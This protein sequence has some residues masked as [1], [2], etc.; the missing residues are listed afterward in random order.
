MRKLLN[1]CSVASF[2]GYLVLSQIFGMRI[3]LVTYF[4]SGHYLNEK[5]AT[6]IS[7]HFK[8]MSL[9]ASEPLKNQQE[10]TFISEGVLRSHRTDEKGNDITNSFFSE[11]DFLISAAHPLQNKSFELPGSQIESISEATI[12]TL[13]LENL[14]HICSLD[15]KYLEVFYTIVKSTL[16]AKIFE[17]AEMRKLRAK[18]RYMHFMDNSNSIFSRVPLQYVS[19]YLDIAPQSLSRIR[20]NII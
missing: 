14:S 13:S 19:S 20:R 3:D 18:Q 15:R 2:S 11:G 5:D 1:I 7:S 9:K 10:I 6:F 16:H 8:S 12:L 4:I 17:Q